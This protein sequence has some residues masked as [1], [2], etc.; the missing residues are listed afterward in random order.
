[1]EA[2]SQRLTV[3]LVDDAIGQ[4][5]K[6]LNPDS[7]KGSVLPPIPEEPVML[8]AFKQFYFNA[9]NSNKVPKNLKSYDSTDF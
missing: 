3:I 6:K 7:L 5:D 9:S 4:L 1:M 2:H 8:Q